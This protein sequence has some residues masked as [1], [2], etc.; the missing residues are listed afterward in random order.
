M[1]SLSSGKASPNLYGF[2]VVVFVIEKLSY[3]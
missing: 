2:V 1:L 3:L